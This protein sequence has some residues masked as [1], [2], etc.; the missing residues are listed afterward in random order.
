MPTNGGGTSTLS[1]RDIRRFRRFE[2]FGFGAPRPRRGAL[3]GGLANLFN[4]Q[5]EIYKIKRHRKGKSHRRIYFGA[6][7]RYRELDYDSL[8]FTN[9]KRDRVIKASTVLGYSSTWDNGQKLIGFGGKTTAG[10]DSSPSL[11][12]KKTWDQTNPG[13]P[14]RGGGPFKSIEYHLPASS[15]Q[16]RGRYTNQGRSGL[17]PYRFGVYEGSFMDNG[18]WLGESYDS[19]K[20]H[21]MP[22][23]NSLSSYY[24]AAWDKTK[25]TIPKA[26]L[27][28]FVYELKDLPGQLKTS[29]EAF[30]REWRYFNGSSV[31][32]PW[33]GG[34]EAA[35]NFL[36]H[37]FGWVPFLDDLGKIF[38]TISRINE[39]ITRTVRDNGQW[40]KR[41]SVLEESETVSAEAQGGVDSA[42]IPSSG[43]LDPENF[44]MCRMTTVGGTT[45]RGHCFF[46][47][48]TTK[49]VWA[50][51]EFKYFLPEFDMNNFDGSAFDSLNVV[52]QWMTLLGL[53]INPTLIWKIMPWSWLVDW[54]TSFGDYIRR[55]DDWVQDSIVARGLF[56]MQSEKK[57]MT[58]T[59]TLHFYSG[60][61][62]LQFQRTLSIKQREMADGL[63]GFNK[64]WNS[65]S[66]KQWAILGAIGISRSSAGYISHGA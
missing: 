47:T 15:I 24:T 38:N 30:H 50:C 56:V 16:G 32:V 13:P 57:V 61:V 6:L 58:K 46:Q 10:S 23:L 64:P 2:F 26:N 20:S 55:L 37:N 28:Q 14:Y 25:P 18:F 65:L 45:Q 41:R 8:F 22:P 39:H 4:P 5:R 1:N 31:A 54:F 34:R 48:I 51:G 49:K 33:I 60:D 63:Y 21:T 52:H 19:L 43:I 3:G 11:H 35:D 7:S 36:N 40:R 27:A 17:T 42:T 9:R 29:S 66:A 59:S 53:R 12:I 62:T 44:P